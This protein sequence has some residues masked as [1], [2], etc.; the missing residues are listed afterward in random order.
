LGDP[1]F[2]GARRPAGGAAALRA[3]SPRV[4][5]RT[6]WKWRAELRPRPHHHRPAEVRDMVWDDGRGQAEL[7]CVPDDL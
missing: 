1:A 7:S 2:L 4:L 3:A 6:V 5:P